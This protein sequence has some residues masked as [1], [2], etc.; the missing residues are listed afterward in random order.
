MKIK[1]KPIRKLEE[2]GKGAV[3]IFPAVFHWLIM[4]SSG[5]DL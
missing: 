5:Y 2:S 4:S 1:R 3:I